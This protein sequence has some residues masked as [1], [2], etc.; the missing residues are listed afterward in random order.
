MNVNA[1]RLLFFLAIAWSATDNQQCDNEG[2]QETPREITNSSAVVGEEA[3]W[4]IIARTKTGTLLA[5]FAGSVP[6]SGWQIGDQ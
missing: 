3:H 5:A 6:R 1:R 2:G 4:A